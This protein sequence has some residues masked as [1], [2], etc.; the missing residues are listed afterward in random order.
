M[1]TATISALFGG[2]LLACVAGSRVLNPSEVGWVMHGDWQQHFLGWHFFRSEPWQWPPGHITSLYEPIGSAIGYTDSIPLLAFVLK[3]FSAWLPNPFQY[4]GLWFLLCFTL[5]GFFGALV[6]STWTERRALQIIGAML[7]V[8]LP[9]LFARI[10][11][12]ALCA[13]WL[14]LWALWLVWRQPPTSRNDAINH[15]ALGLASGLVHPY[16]AVMVLALVGALAARRAMFERRGVPGLAVF[17]WAIGAVALGWWASGLL[18]LG[19][20]QDL[21]ANTGAFSMNV[22]SIVNPGP[23]SILL[24]GFP[25]VSANSFGEGYQYLGAGILL[26]LIIGGALAARTRPWSPQTIPLA[27]VSVACLVYSLVPEIAIGRRVLVDFVDAFSEIAMFRSTG[28]F[29]WPVGY[30]LAAAAFG[31]VATKLKPK[32]AGVLLS[33]V[34]ALQIADLHRWWLEVHDGARDDAFFRWQ[35]P[36]QSP[37]WHNLLPRYRHMRLYSPEFC[38]GP[39]PV[40]TAAAAYLAGLYGLGLNDGYAARVDAAKQAAACQAFRDDFAR[41]VVDESTVY[42]LSP[43][44]AADFNARTAAY[45]E[46]REIDGVTV[47]VSRR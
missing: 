10:A 3:P 13:H 40:S 19:C 5:Q 44:F 8:L 46:C 32:T 15:L 14:L 37:E 9:T 2:A 20:A 29:F 16:L 17:G 6:I 26:L 23:R 47:C 27:L 36:L 7:L 24:P 41:G 22:L 39:V 4:I 38:R 43:A 45:A 25:V 34:L 35:M 18:T 31:V 42:L 11:H 12:P 1:K 21:T 28:R 30:A 33:A